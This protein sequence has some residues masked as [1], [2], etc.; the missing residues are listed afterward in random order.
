MSARL[1]CRDSPGQPCRSFNLRRLRRRIRRRRAS[2]VEASAGGRGQGPSGPYSMCY[3]IS[4]SDDPMGSYYRYEF[5]RPLFPDYP[6]P[7]IW[8][9]G[10]Y[11]PTST[12]DDVIEKHACVVER[13]KM[14]KGEPATRAVRRARRRGLSQQRGR[15]WQGDAAGGRAQHH[16]DRRRLA[17]EERPRR[18]RRVC[19]AVRRRLEGRVEDEG[20]RAGQDR[21]RAVSLSVRRPAQELRAAAAAP[22]AGSIRR[23]TRSCRGS[24]I[25]GSAVANRSS[26]CTR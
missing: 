19:V 24:Y 9:D 26:A 23:A 17:A 6:R 10:Y 4:S 5:L 22:T 8:R 13:A 18:R 2:A 7:A 20:D 16:D 12:G 25:A 14:L 3:A 21:R 11:V 15:R 1:A